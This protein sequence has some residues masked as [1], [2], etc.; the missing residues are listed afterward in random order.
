VFLQ[1]VRLSRLPEWFRSAGRVGH[2]R[3]RHHLLH[4]GQHWIVR[5]P[6]S[7]WFFAVSHRND[8]IRI[9][10]QILDNLEQ[11]TELAAHC[12]V[13]PAKRLP[14]RD[15]VAA[16]SYRKTGHAGSSANTTFLLVKPPRLWRQLRA[17]SGESALESAREAAN[18]RKRGDFAR[19]RPG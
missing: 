14:G 19:A 16:A 15:R 12:F 11:R 9:E 4:G 6:V 1:A 8:P 2:A 7:F 3:F 5:I 13:L 10:E 18:L 17:E